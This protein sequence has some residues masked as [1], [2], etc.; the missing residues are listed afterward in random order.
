MFGGHDEDINVENLVITHNRRKD[1]RLK[2]YNKIY[3]KCVNKIKYIND[4]LLE[5]DCYF[6]IPHFRWGLPF[7][8]HK[9]AL[10][11]IMIKLRGKGFEVKYVNDDAI[12][13]NW[14]KI[15]ESAMND[16][17]PARHLASIDGVEMDIGDTTVPKPSN[18]TMKDDRFHKL[19]MEGC[20]GECCQDKKIQAQDPERKRVTKKQ[21][22]EIARQQQQSRIQDLLRY[23][24]Y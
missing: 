21:H 8:Q 3:T 23:K 1:T 11:F 13:I 18:V 22:L 19:E 12:Y 7:Y 20:G 14:N 4:V 16:S 24:N 15:V 17:Y 6:S 5:R 2:V 10:G 9:A